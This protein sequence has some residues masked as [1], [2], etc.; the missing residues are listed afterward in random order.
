MAIQ[1][2]AQTGATS[3]ATAITTP[4]AVATIFPPFSKRR[5]T[6]RA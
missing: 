1:I 6:G 2:A 3:G 4:P 5:K